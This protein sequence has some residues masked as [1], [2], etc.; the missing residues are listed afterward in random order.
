MK[1]RLILL[2]SL[3]PLL[4]LGQT[5]S[6]ARPSIGRFGRFRGTDVPF[7]PSGRNC[8]AEAAAKPPAV[9]VSPDDFVKLERTS[10]FGGYCPVYTVKIHADG[11]VVW[12]R[13]IG[14]GLERPESSRVQ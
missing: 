6:V 3:S 9:A 14:P 1:T 10:C 11:R 8:P 7:R 2:L 4:L 12:Q 5:D 13:K